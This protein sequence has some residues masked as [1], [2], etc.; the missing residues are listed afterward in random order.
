MKRAVAQL[1]LMHHSAPTL[2]GRQQALPLS[3]PASVAWSLRAGQ[4]ACDAGA[5][6]VVSG[7]I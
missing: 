1:K 7:L 6:D 3:K 2:G 5:V 4:H